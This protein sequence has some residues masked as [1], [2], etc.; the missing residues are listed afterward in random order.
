M[1]TQGVSDCGDDDGDGEGDDDD[2]DG[3]N[4]MYTYSP[5]SC[6]RATALYA[7]MYRTVC[8]VIVATLSRKLR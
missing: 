5:Q 3:C 2:D 8:S 1:F 6:E 4:N 7:R